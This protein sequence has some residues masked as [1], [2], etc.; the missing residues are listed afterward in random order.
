MKKHFNCFVFCSDTDSMIYEIKHLAFYEE[1]ATNDDLRQHF[2]FSNYPA[3][4]HL[5]NTENK[6]VTL[7]FKDELA[8]VPI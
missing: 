1:Q 6:M 4:H 3:D 5:F 7:K 2:D 8:G